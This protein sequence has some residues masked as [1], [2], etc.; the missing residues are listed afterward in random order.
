MTT[1]QSTYATTAAANSVTVNLTD[2]SVFAN[3]IVWND[4]VS[5]GAAFAANG[6][7]QT[8]SQTVLWE[9]TNVGRVD[10]SITGINNDLPLSS[11][12]P[13]ASFS[14]PATTKH[15]KS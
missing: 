6:L 7:A 10:I 12:L 9:L 14:R 2:Y 15:W 8:L 1:G 11:R 5:L 4:D 3:G 13:A